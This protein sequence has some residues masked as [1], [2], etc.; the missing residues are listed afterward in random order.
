VKII[1]A[2][3]VTGLVCSLLADCNPLP[4]IIMIAVGWVVWQVAQGIGAAP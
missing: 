4:V 2:L 1:L 3:V